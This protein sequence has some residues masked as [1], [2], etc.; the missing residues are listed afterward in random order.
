MSDLGPL[1]S[2][3]PQVTVTAATPSTPAPT[4]GAQTPVTPGGAQPQTQTPSSPTTVL[5]G[6]SDA[7]EIASSA[8]ELAKGGQISAQVVARDNS[9]LLVRTAAGN[10]LA[11]TNLAQAFEQAN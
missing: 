9:A 8:S 5:Q 10:T 1:V 4:G 2:G 11:L 6:G 3:T 7:T